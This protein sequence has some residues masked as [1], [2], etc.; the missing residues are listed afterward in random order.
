[1]T[2]RLLSISVTG[3]PVN[4]PG[5]PHRLR[6]WTE[7]SPQGH[8]PLTSCFH[9]RTSGPVPQP[10]EPGRWDRPGS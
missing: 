1:M 7:A 4:A 6:R 10:Q 8:V 5:T 3:P 9:L 2:K